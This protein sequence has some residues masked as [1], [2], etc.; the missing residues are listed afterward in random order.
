M[1]SN[2]RFFPF[3]NYDLAND[4]EKH[5]TPS[6]PIL[7]LVFR[8]SLLWT[9]TFTVFLCCEWAL[10][11]LWLS[12]TNDDQSMFGILLAVVA[13]LHACLSFVNGCICNTKV[14]FE[15]WPLTPQYKPRPRSLDHS[16]C[17]PSKY[18]VL[19]TARLE[20]SFGEIR[21]PWPRRKIRILLDKTTRRS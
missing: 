5:L 14:I 20:I 1:A 19:G 16:F 15:F 9:G 11:F 10:I 8:S 18:F 13:L 21:N 4:P 2:D 12:A 7:I 6:D 17:A 3:R